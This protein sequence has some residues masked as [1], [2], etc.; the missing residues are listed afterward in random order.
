MADGLIQRKVD[1]KLYEFQIFGAK[2]ALKTL[3]KLTKIIGEPLTLAFTALGVGDKD[4]KGKGLLDRKIDGVML[5]VAVKAL[6]TRMDEDEVLD[7]IEELAGKDNLLCD[8]KKVIFD[9]HYEGKLGHLMRVVGAALEVQY[10]DFLEEMFAKA[11]SSKASTT[12][13]RRT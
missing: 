10:G 13:A 2:H 4:N 3:T 1:G 6:T 11:G 7:L 5:G 9:S 12:A 8:G